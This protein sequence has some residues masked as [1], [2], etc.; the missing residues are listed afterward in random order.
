[1]YV[2]VVGAAIAVVLAYG[3]LH[4]AGAGVEVMDDFLFVKEV[5]GAEYSRLVDVEQIF[6]KVAERESAVVALHG[7]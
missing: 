2:G 1:M 7:I 3:I 4:G 6:F 5:D